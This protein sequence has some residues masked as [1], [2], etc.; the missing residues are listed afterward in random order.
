MRPAASSP[1]QTADM[2]TLYLSTPN[3]TQNEVIIKQKPYRPLFSFKICG[4]AAS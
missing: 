4:M 2:I 1:D 3:F